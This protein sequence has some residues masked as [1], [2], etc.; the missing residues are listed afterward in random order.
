MKLLFIPIFA[1][2]NRWRGSDWPFKHIPF[3]AKLLSGLILGYL[4]GGKWWMYPLMIGLYFLGQG[5]FSWEN[6]IGSILRRRKD[7][8]RARETLILIGFFWW[9]LC[10]SP[11]L[12]TG[13]NIPITISTIAIAAIGF[14]LN[15][16]MARLFPCFEWFDDTYTE[17]WWR[18][19]EIIYGAIQGF[20]IYLIVR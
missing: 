3:I 9:G 14:P 17:N 4:L 2:L 16:E 7:Y 15:F 10:L 5:V 20:C 8:L 11:F 1:I 13:Y 18:I 6:Q 12:F 19:G